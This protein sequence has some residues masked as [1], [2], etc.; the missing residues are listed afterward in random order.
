MILISLES[1]LR[2]LGYGYPTDF[3]IKSQVK[4]Q[5]ICTDNQR[6]SWQFFPTS[7]ARKPNRFNI[8]VSRP[9]GT[10]RIFVLGSS[11]AMGDPDASFSFSRILKTLL[12]TRYPATRFEVINAA[13]TAINSHVILPIAR[14]C[15]TCQP[16]LFI[17]YMGNNEVVGPFGSGTI[18]GQFSPVLSLIS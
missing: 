1:S 3:I 2:I 16:D 4:G 15:A 5:E 18:F 12:R 6:F 13:M 7:L 17:V 9:N 14:D 10:F 11:A 8:P